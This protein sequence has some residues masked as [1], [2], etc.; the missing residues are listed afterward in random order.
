MTQEM[1]ARNPR[2]IPLKA[3]DEAEISLTAASGLRS[4]FRMFGVPVLAFTVFYV[5]TGISTGW[6]ESLCVPAG[7]T[8]LILA[9]LVLF[10][11][12]RRNAALPEIL[13]A[14]GTAQGE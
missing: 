7:L 2:N 6:K 8:G 14:A 1:R 4:A 11:T 3:G 10:F 12:G 9:A 13:R 5:I